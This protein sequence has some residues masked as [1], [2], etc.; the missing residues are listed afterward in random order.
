MGGASFEDKLATGRRV[1]DP[2]FALEKWSRVHSVPT[3]QRNI[4][5]NQSPCSM[6]P[7][8]PI[9]DRESDQSS[10]SNRAGHCDVPDKPAT[11]L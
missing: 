6:S 5:F 4:I 3:R 1:A 10:V 7:I 8:G 11:S 2:D 9:R